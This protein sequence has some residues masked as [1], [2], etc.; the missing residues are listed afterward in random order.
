MPT[1]SSAASSRRVDKDVMKLQRK[2]QGTISKG[3]V[4]SG[5]YYF[6]TLS[7][8]SDADIISSF[9]E[10]RITRATI[11]YTLFTQPNNNA[12]FPCLTEAPQRIVDTTTAPTAITEVEQFG[13]V[14]MFQFGPADLTY[15]R[16]YTPYVNFTVSGS[17]KAPVASPWLNTLSDSVPHMT[18][19]YWLQNYNSPTDNS[20]T[21]RINVLLDIEVRGPK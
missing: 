21:L 2:V 7:G 19:V 14:K 10:Y 15:T 3:A 9:S 6:T 4:D 16:S 17:G 11:T 18:H 20:H 12:N 1:K 13:K 8:F 5:Q